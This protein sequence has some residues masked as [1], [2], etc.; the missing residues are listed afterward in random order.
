MKNCE[1]LFNRTKEQKG[2]FPIKA[3][4]NPIIITIVFC[5]RLLADKGFSL[6]ARGEVVIKGKGQM[7]TWFLTGSHDKDIPA[8]HDDASNDS[9]ESST[10]N[11]T[12]V[13]LNLGNG[14]TLQTQTHRNQKKDSLVCTLL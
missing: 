3:M 11:R 9:N 13:D 5:F 14:H 6:Q 4:T 10:S 8:N 1:A 2:I 12:S 7:K